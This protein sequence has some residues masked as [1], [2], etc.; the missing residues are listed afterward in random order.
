MDAE[1]FHK[2]QTTYIKIDDN[3][4]VTKKQLK[5]FTDVSSY[6]SGSYEDGTAFNNLTKQLEEIEKTY[7]GTVNRVFY[8]AL[9]S[10]VFLSVAKNLKEHCYAA[11][12]DNRIVMAAPFGKDDNSSSELDWSIRQ[13]W[14]EDEIYRVEPYLGK[15]MVRNLP[16]LRFTN[17]AFLSGWDKES[18][19]NVQIT[20]KESFGTEGRGGLFDEFGIIRDVIQ[21]RAYPLYFGFTPLTLAP[22]RLTPSSLRPRHGM[23]QIR[24]SQL[25]RRRRRSRRES[26]VAQGDCTDCANGYSAWSVCRCQREAWL[27]RRRHSSFAIEMPNVCCNST[28]YLQLSLGWRSFHS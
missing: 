28:P 12:G 27:S 14:V 9:P 21:N 2:R 24:R 20:F 19:S 16:F 11:N 26:H 5:E 18:I 7:N 1:E 13:Y 10:N 6:I 4:T 22:Y 17:S 23:P 8:F 3:D 25:R 15:E